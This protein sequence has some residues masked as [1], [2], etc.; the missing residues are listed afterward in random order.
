MIW[1]EMIAGI[2]ESKSFFKNTSGSGDSS[3]DLIEEVFSLVGAMPKYFISAVEATVLSVVE[4]VVFFFQTKPANPSYR[5]EGFPF[6]NDFPFDG[7][8]NWWSCIFEAPNMC[9]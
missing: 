6:V 4:N 5:V 2:N 9:C 7:I 8:W 1:V 3:F